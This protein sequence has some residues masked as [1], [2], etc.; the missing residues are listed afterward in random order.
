MPTTRGQ[1]NLLARPTLTAVPPTPPT[2][3]RVALRPPLAPRFPGS[4]QPRRAPTSA[5]WRD[6]ASI[7]SGKQVQV[8]FRPSRTT[9]QFLPGATCPD[10]AT[11][12]YRVGILQ[13][14]A[15]TLVVGEQAPSLV[16]W[17]VIQRCVLDLLPFLEE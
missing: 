8:Q 13:A 12:T 9:A 11:S 6:R 2:F 5:T 15:D 10:L 3:R 1:P 14:V 16:G 4:Q 7:S 17:F